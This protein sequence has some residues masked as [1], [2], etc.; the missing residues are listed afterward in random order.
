MG[1]DEDFDL[2]YRK[3]EEYEEW[4]KAD[5]VKIQREKLITLGFSEDRI[6]AIENV[7]H[8]KIDRGITA[9]KT[10]PFASPRV[11]NEDVYA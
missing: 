4:A 7:L 2:G 9:A 6:R 8:E 1:V 3:K 5:P 11:L 10:A